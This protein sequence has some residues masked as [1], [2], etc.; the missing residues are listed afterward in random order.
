[1]KEIKLKKS[2]FL[3]FIVPL[4]FIPLGC[5]LIFLNLDRHG[6]MAHRGHAIGV[7]FILIF[8][9]KFFFDLCRYRSQSITINKLGIDDK[10]SFLIGN[11]YEWSQ[12]TGLSISNSML[13]IK[14]RYHTVETPGLKITNKDKQIIEKYIQEYV[15]KEG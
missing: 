12:I 3:I 2:L 1:M 5:L 6:V 8:S 13:K 9:V 14:T 4:I 15:N 11:K 7:I 10:T